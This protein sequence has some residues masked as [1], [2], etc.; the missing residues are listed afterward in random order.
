[1]NKFVVLAIA[2]LVCPLSAQAQTMVGEEYQKA[3]EA[4]KVKEYSSFLT[5][6]EKANELR[7]NHRTILYNL[8]VAYALNQ[9][10]QSAIETLGY[11]ASFYAMKD[12]SEDED[13]KDLWEMEAY[14]TLL[15][16]I[17]EK[18]TPI[19]SSELQFEFSQPGFH[20]E[21]LAIHPETGN[22]LISDVRCG[23]ISSFTK[24]GANRKQILD[25]K[26]FGFWGAMG[27]KFDA[28]D[29][30]VLW[31][32]TS[33]LPE[34]CNYSEELAGKSALLKIDVAKRKLLKA[35]QLE[36]DHV[37]G[38]LTMDA[39]GEI[40]VSDSASPSI[41]KLNRL[42]NQLEEFLSHEKWFNLQG[43]VIGTDNKMYVS[44]YIMGVYE[45]DLTTK[46]VKTVLDENQLTR[47]TDGLYFTGNKLVLLQNGTQP[48]QV[49]EV[50]LAKTKSSSSIKALERAI[51]E[52]NEPTL[53]AIHDDVLYFISN[54]PWA[55][56]KDGK[57]II[58]QWPTLQIRKIALKK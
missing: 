46:L 3:N 7:P 9:N 34:F 19:S 16:H 44:D 1:M 2:L 17:D 48:F 41:Y 10:F 28:N 11:R 26:E 53:G 50:S 6:I 23:L 29:S 13:L 30:N 15:A 4:Y 51:P 47:G 52:L 49:A 37:F 25:L 14:Q 57:P 55:F 31:V 8:A 56:Y 35:Y 38:D 32:T 12:F 58:E 42:N 5:H 24:E 33:A 36:G 43:L 54:S 39:S 27:M 18:N 20:P 40:Y 22:F 45:V 21:G